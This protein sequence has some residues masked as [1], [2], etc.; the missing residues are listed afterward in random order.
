[1]SAVKFST[2]TVEIERRIRQGI[3]KDKLP[4]TLVLAEEFNV[5][6]QTMTNALRPL[7]EQQIIISS[8]K[9]GMLI[10]E[11]ASW[12]CGLIAIINGLSLEQINFYQSLRIECR[13]LEKEGFEP[14]ILG[15]PASYRFGNPARFFRFIP[16]N[17]RGILFT[18]SSLTLDMAQYLE[19]INVPFLSCNRLPVYP[20]LN[21]V[22]TDDFSAI[23][24]VIAQLT[25]LNYRRIAFMFISHLEGYRNFIHQEWQKIVQ[26]FDLE[27][28]P[29]NYFDY[30]T[31]LTNHDLLELFSKAVHYGERP[32]IIVIWGC[33]MGENK[34][35]YQIMQELLAI[36]VPVVTTSQLAFELYKG[37]NIFLMR[38]N[39]AE[40]LYPAAVSAM[41][42]LV[43]AQIKKPIHRLIPF[44]L[45]F[46]HGLPPYNKN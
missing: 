41:M 8:G 35:N 15:L 5:A 28:M 45:V 17:I 33:Y 4:T 36:N 40:K 24:K 16:N 11:Q 43:M 38:L 18:Q 34:E 7:V 32:D 30:N 23:R 26:E 1:M 37:R 21:Y 20:K 13:L 12:Q 10:N 31:E 44:D 3:Y 2:I 14:L 27:D 25:A 46:P 29:C 9:R 22:E 39:S 42:E 6:R 19:T